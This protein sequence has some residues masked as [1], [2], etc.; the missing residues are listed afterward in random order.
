MRA[1]LTAMV[2]V[3]CTGAAALADELSALARLDA[4]RSSIEGSGGGL[5]VTLGLSQ[6]VPWRVRLLDSP[7]RL[8]LDTREVDWAAIGTLERPESGLADLRAGTVRSGW[9]RLVME[10][11]SPMLVASAGMETGD[12]RALLTIRLA[13][14][15]AEEFAA[16]A[17]QPE[18]PEWA[19]PKAAD[20]PKALPRGTGP[21]VVVLDP[22]HGG[23]D[24]G[25]ERDKTFEKDIVLTFARELKEALL[26]AGGFTVVMTRDEDVF[27]P[28]E[29]RISIANAAA[30]DVFISIHADALAEGEAVG[31]T[32][33]T[34]SEDA[35]DRAAATL[36]ERHD[37]DELLSG[38]D[39]TDQDDTVATVLMDL[40]RTETR[41][42][43]EA[44]AIDLRDAILA[45]GLKMH[46]VPLQSAGFS[47]LKLP[48]IPSL[49]LEIGFLSSARDHARMT[50]PEW[51]AKLAKAIVSGLLVWAK[52]DAARAQIPRD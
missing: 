19:L 8:V 12:G 14:A 11:A 42:R 46:R 49:L 10:L 26:R 35:S 52:E 40:A 50:D 25:A 37:R 6:P 9:S 41:P 33:Y 47:V 45:D 15:T 39:L 2:L 5:T 36:A 27:V 17:S 20:L 16:R 1:F 43:T 29:T 24:P 4:A 34:L 28:L 32:I 31:A 30:A 51:R 23:I 18:P 38:V 3:L 22:G 21:L 13:P 44:L 7:P 48:D